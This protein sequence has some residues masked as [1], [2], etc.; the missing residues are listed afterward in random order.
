VPANVN[1]NHWALFIINLATSQILLA[2]SLLAQ[3]PWP[4]KELEHVTRF[5]QANI[6]P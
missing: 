6:S 1:K 4:K 3:D 5:V 2:D